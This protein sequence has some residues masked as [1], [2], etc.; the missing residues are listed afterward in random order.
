MLKTIQL[1]Y[2]QIYK[3]GKYKATYFDTRGSHV[4][5]GPYLKSIENGQMK[6][7]KV[8]SEQIDHMYQI[9]QS[10][11]NELWHYDY[12]KFDNA[13]ID[14]TLLVSII[15]NEIDPQSKDQGQRYYNWQN[16]SSPMLVVGLLK[17]F[18]KIIN[19]G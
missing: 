12:K 3:D 7:F 10:G 15:D 5:Q 4:D 1:T 11:F 18:D 2:N 8:S 9:I 6:L 14:N 16:N 19:E 13:E 17:H